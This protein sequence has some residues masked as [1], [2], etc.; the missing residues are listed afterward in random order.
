[1]MSGMYAVAGVT[2]HTG[3]VVAETLQAEGQPLR[4]IVRDEKKV[5]TWKDR[6]AEVAV[7]AVDDEAA[8]TR[9]LS[10]TKGAYVL[11]PPDAV[12]TDFFGS[13]AR[14]IDAIARAAVN[15]RLP[16][17][18]LLSSIGAHLPKGHGPIGALYQAERRFET[19][20][21]GTTFVRASYFLEN[22]GAGLPAA[23]NDGVLP[24]FLP[25]KLT[26]A[27]VTT[28]DIGRTAAQAL[29]DGPRGRRVVE[30][31]GPADVT[32]ADVAAALTELL[33][34]TVHVVEAPLD[35]VVPTFTSFGMSQQMAELYREM[36]ASFIGGITWEGKGERVRGSTGV[37]E[38]LRA[39]LG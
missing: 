11:L 29:L 1:M 15:A 26:H 9:A 38:G 30:L 21:I 35:A 17:L 20:G 6:G 2:G 33:G 7:A 32:P 3:G 37:K 10:G 39:M 36:Y 34:R 19:L 23:K 16:H 13:R 5:A 8:L 31:S 22:Y 18:V 4:V 14:I 25:A 28:P 27:V 12:T 24:S